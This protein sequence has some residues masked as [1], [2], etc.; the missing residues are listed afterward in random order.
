MMFIDTVK[1]KKTL[2]SSGIAYEKESLVLFWNSIKDVVKT[3]YL[4]HLQLPTS[5]YFLYW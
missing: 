5:L 2:M 1:W 3:V 4:I